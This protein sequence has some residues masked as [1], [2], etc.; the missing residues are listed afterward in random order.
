M[1]ISRGK[2]KKGKVPY[3][4]TTPHKETFPTGAG[5]R[6][7]KAN[8][9]K[10]NL[11]MQ[12]GIYAKEMMVPYEETGRRV[13]FSPANISRPPGARTRNL[14]LI[15]PL[16][17]PIELVDNEK[18]PETNLDARQQVGK[19]ELPSFLFSWCFWVQGCKMEISGRIPTDTCLPAKG[20]RRKRNLT[21]AKGRNVM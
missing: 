13:Y 10:R 16:L 14:W 8:Q 15:R 1:F 12:G 20:V 9:S 19:Q 3:A 11:Y 6:T 17:S 4:G 21:S 18:D 2:K 7:R 5:T